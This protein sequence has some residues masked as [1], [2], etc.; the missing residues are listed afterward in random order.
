MINRLPIT[1][2]TLALRVFGAKDIGKW[3]EACIVA[4]AE[5]AQACLLYTS[6]GMRIYVPVLWLVPD[7]KS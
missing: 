7:L 5:N 2:L 1:A 3:N 6:A 4:I